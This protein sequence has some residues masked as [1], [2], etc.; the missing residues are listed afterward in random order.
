MT[1]PHPTARSGTHAPRSEGAEGDHAIPGAHAAA[2]DLRRDRRTIPLQH[3]PLRSALPAPS[4]HALTAP[5][6]RAGGGSR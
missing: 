4:E 5:P 1:S 6:V 2:A 3:P